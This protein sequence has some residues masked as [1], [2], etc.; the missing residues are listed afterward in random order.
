MTAMSHPNVFNSDDPETVQIFTSIHEED[1]FSVCRSTV[2]CQVQIQIL[3]IH[4]LG[5]IISPRPHREVYREVVL[6]VVIYSSLDKAL[7]K[8]REKKGTVS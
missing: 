6:C 2:G 5:L 4:N 7:L 3:F 8:R 1:L